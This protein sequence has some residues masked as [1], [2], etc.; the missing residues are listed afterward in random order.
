M[1]QVCADLPRHVWLAWPILLP[2]RKKAP[3][4][5][6]RLFAE[7][8]APCETEF[9]HRGGQDEGQVVGF[10]L[11]EQEIDNVK[12]SAWEFLSEEDDVVR[13]RCPSGLPADRFRD[14][15]A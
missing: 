1:L 2:T 7:L 9:H 10:H 8:H 4:I 11:C 12:S 5:F 13:A 3:R 15:Q 14:A 6:Y